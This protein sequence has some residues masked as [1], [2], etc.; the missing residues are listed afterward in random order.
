MF[1]NDIWYPGNDPEIFMYKEFI[2]NELIKNSVIITDHGC[3]RDFSTDDAGKICT[4]YYPNQLSHKK[5]LECFYIEDLF[6][7]YVV[8]NYI[9]EIHKKLFLT[10]DSKQLIQGVSS[11]EEAKNYLLLS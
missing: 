1:K 8:Y 11:I 7:C 3:Q 2:T 6:Y 5:F 9:Q 4:I 10:L